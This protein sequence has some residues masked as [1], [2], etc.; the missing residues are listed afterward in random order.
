MDMEFERTLE[1][2]KRK[3]AMLQSS[4]VIKSQ[5]RIEQEQQHAWMVAGLVFP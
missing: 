1:L 5:T 3:P 4:W 2:V